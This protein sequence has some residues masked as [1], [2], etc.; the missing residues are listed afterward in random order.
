MPPGL[1][2]LD[3]SSREAECLARLHAGLWEHLYRS[4]TAE[5]AWEEFRGHRTDGGLPV[6]LVAE[7]DG[8]LVGS[9]SVT[10]GDCEARMDLDPWLASLWVA[11]AHRGKGWAGRLIRGAIDLA[12]A[13][14]QPRLHVFTESAESLFIRHGF[15]VI[16]RPVLHGC[17]VA[18]LLRD[19]TVAG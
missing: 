9:V 3:G 17:A 4:W 6:T 7:E 8:E 1:R 15:R 11:P 5:A 2:L 13:N 18:I 19:G 14:G 12:E 10:T 16:D